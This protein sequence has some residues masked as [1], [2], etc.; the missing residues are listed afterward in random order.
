MSPLLSRLPVKFTELGAKTHLWHDMFTY[1]YIAVL[2]I[3]CMIK[4]KLLD[5]RRSIL[6]L[7]YTRRPRGVSKIGTVH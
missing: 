2:V 7:V 1:S 4:Y 3:A 5:I 6:Q